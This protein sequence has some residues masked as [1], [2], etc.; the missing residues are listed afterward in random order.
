MQ[1]KIQNNNR[2]ITKS[3]HASCVPFEQ[4]TS[5]GKLYSALQIIF[6]WW[7]FMLF[8]VI[9]YKKKTSENL[10]FQ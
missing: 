9:T 5:G 10:R 8:Y 1:I 7:Y 6:I 3:N 2:K 4:L